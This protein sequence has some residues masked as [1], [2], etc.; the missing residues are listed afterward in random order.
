M[1][2]QTSPERAYQTLETAWSEWHQQWR[3]HYPE[4]QTMTYN[5]DYEG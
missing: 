3:S 2:L 1:P 4:F 5:K